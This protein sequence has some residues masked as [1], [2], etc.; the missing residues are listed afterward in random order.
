MFNVRIA[1]KQAELNHNGNDY[2]NYCSSCLA[3]LCGFTQQQL[4][5]WPDALH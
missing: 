2:F 1:E 4:V 3:R 5:D